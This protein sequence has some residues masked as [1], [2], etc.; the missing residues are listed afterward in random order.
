MADEDTKQDQGGTAAAVPSLDPPEPVLSA[1][2]ANRED[3]IQNAVS[4]LTHPKARL[5]CA[6][7]G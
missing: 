6:L 7:Q 2:T 3:Q 4:F 5:L 1:I